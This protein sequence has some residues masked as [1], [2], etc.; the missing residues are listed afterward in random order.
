LIKQSLA[1]SVLSAAMETG[2][3]FAELFIE[4]RDSLILR[5]QAGNVE[6]INSARVHGAGVR[7]F[8]GNRS[9]Y[10]Y[11]N[12]TSERS[13]LNA[14]K[15][16]AA[17]LSG[18]PNVL[19]IS[20]RSASYPA[21]S[22]IA[23]YPFTVGYEPKLNLLRKAHKASKGY[24]ELVT[25]VT[26]NMAEVD[27]RV[28]I[29][30]SEGLWG[31]SRRVRSRTFAFSTASSGTEF[32]TGYESKGYTMGFE[33]YDGTVDV[34]TVAKTASQRAVD[35]LSAPECPAGF[36]PVVIESGAGVIFHEACGHSLEA[37]SVAP[38]NSVFSGKLGQQIAAP[39]VSAV[40]DGTI[41]NAWGTTD[42]DDE[43][44]PTQRNLLIE[45]GILKGYLIDKLGGRRLKMAPTGSARRESYEQAPT[46]RMNN[47]F[48]CEGTD[49]NEAM[50]RTM[51]EGLFAKT[52]GGGQVNPLTGEFNFGVEEGYWVKDGKIVCP[53]RGGVLIGKGADV[54]MNIDRVG[55]KLGMGV[56]M[57]GS[58]SGSVP[59]GMGQPRIRVTG[60]TVGGKGAKI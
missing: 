45:N 56:G 51:G 15:Q 4:D 25:Q 55:T 48:I 34:E 29:A 11:C 44:N 20:F 40:D 53:V 57:C 17:A 2:A 14:A 60:M 1:Q 32:Q 42:M 28:L 37:T 26:L 27:Q 12:D 59:T 21:H 39:C 24:S 3:D 33:M 58:L 31:E 9:I 18:S 7:I 5:M 50:I 43:G 35:A 38:G 36:F 23:V 19:D 47:T 6:N 52:M 30:N 8:L 54:L 10:V 22:P 16:A 13:L 41:Q 46:S 49:D